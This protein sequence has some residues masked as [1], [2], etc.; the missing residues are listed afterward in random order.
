MSNDIDEIALMTAKAIGGI[1]PDKLPGGTTQ[2]VARAQCLIRDAIE[3]AAKADSAKGSEPVAFA[4]YWGGGEVELYEAPLPS[5][6]D[7]PEVVAPLYTRPQ[8][9]QQGGLPERMTPDADDGPRTSAF[10]SGWNSAIDAMLSTNTT[11]P[12]SEWVRCSERLP[13][14]RDSDHEG[15]VWVVSKLHGIKKMGW[16][17]VRAKFESYWMPTGLKRPQPPKEGE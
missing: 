1:D 7:E 9:A 8:P 12:G 15:Q 16:S 17:A 10:I 13:T 5:F 6:C 4:V 3:Q 2:A 11:S 14:F